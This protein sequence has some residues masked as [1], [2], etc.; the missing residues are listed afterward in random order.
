M[1]YILRGNRNIY[2]FLKNQISQLFLK[3]DEKGRFKGRGVG[4]Q[5]ALN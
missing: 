1:S 3:N 2:K 5:S 4:P